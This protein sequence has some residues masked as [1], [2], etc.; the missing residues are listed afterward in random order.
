MANPTS[1]SVRRFP[2]G[3]VDTAGHADAESTAAATAAGFTEN[4]IWA[5]ETIL[6]L[7]S[8]CTMLGASFI[9]QHRCTRWKSKKLGHVAFTTFFDEE[10]LRY[11]DD[12]VGKSVQL[13][14]RHIDEVV[15]QI[16]PLDMLPWDFVGIS[17]FMR[18]S[19]HHAL[20]Q[21]K[22]RFDGAP[23]PPE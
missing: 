13:L 22:P 1:S 8:K 15:G 17:G 11:V 23:I 9:H 12:M 10:M 19:P 14:R 3:A 16:A 7:G 21:T 4:H 18:D 5:C 6:S 2:N 20:V